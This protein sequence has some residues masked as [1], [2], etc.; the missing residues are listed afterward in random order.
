MTL[1]RRL[2]N[3][4]PSHHSE[5]I[6]RDH[7]AHSAFLVAAERAGLH[8]ASTWVNGY[9]DYEWRHGRHY[10]AA[11]VGEVS[12]LRVL[13]FGCNV[14]A[15][16]IVLAHCG[17][18]VEAVDISSQILTLAQ[19]NVRSYGLDSRVTLQLLH[20]DGCL[21]FDDATFDV[22]VC[23]SVLEC[24]DPEALISTLHEIDRVLAPDG[25]LVITGTSNRLAPR[26]V[27]SGRWLINYVPRGWER[28]FRVRGTLQRGIS[29]W[30]VRTTLK[31]YH[32]LVLADR[33]RGYFEARLGSG[34]ANWKIKLLRSFAKVTRAF[35]CS[36]G[37]LTPS[38][39]LALRKPG[40]ISP[41]ASLQIRGLAGSP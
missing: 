26:E 29:P 28:L 18:Q 33:A 31:R 40:P 39:F 30:T 17:A 34:T 21:P 25:T 11:Y 9:V 38:F 32:D 24:V 2:R 27:H 12:G 20:T 16:A 37:M 19:L 35:G 3:S 14:G 1:E 22:I 41:R 5:P 10:I 4:A 13:E 23:N 36:I 6:V 8:P 15:T 7:T